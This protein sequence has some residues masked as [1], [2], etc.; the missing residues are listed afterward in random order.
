MAQDQRI[1]HLFPAGG[2]V[3]RELIIGREEVIE[4]LERRIS[5][6]LHTLLSGPRRIGKT[7]V[8]DAAC[9]RMAE[10]GAI[11][12]EVEVPE[13]TTGDALLLAVA[14]SCRQQGSLVET[15]Q[16]AIRAAE[17]LIE[18]ALGELGLPLDLSRLDG[19]RSPETARKVLTLPLKVARAAG[20]PLIFY[21]DE[22]Q[23]AVEYE[24]GE[25]LLGDLVD[26]YS[27]QTEAVLLVDGS[28]ERVL[29]KVMVPPVGFGKLV[30][31]LALAEEIPVRHWRERLPERFGQ[32]RLELAPEALEALISFGRCRPYATMAAAQC[33][34]LNARRLGSHSVGTFEMTEGVAEARRHLAEDQG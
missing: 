24:N 28:E 33:A 29:E 18:K 3:P 2:P 8:C 6:G 34:A 27:G 25:R 13:S 15:G 5:E 23:R 4:E 11:V 32:A 26:V 20:R 22:L 9:E 21:L 10:G 17:P 7:T 30:D 16:R 31:R 14:D 19:D 1:G 12:V